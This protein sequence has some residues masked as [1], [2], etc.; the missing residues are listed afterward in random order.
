[1]RWLLGS[2]ARP[3]PP[4]QPRRQE[5]HGTNQRE[6]CLERDA[7]QPERQRQ[8]P[9]HGKEN[10]REERRGPG[11][12]QQDAPAD[13]KNQSFHMLPFILLGRGFFL[14][15]TKAINSLPE[16]VNP[17]D[18]FPLFPP[19]VGPGAKGGN[20]RLRGWG[21]T[22]FAARMRSHSHLK[23]LAALA[24]LLCLP[25]ACPVQSVACLFTLGGWFVAQ[26][27]SPQRLSLC[28]T[29]CPRPS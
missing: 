23:I 20:S 10:Q 15:S 11:K 4:K 19:F 24:A 1:M 7:D 2:G 28:A 9:D 14:P 18:L 29:S 17:P 26:A 3:S 8:K 16:Y 21:W 25:S 22:H 12:H 27:P 13:K 6:E 5:Q